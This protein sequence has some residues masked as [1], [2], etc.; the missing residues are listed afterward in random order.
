MALSGFVAIAVA[1]GLFILL[2]TWAADWFRSGRQAGAV[3]SNVIEA[4]V[5][6]AVIVGYIA[7]VGFL[8]DIRRVFQYHGAEHAVI[9]C[10]EAGDRVT[11]ENVLK[12]GV[13]HPRCGT[14]FLL[15][16]IVVKLVVNCF[17]G[18]PDLWV[19]MLLRVAVLPLVAALA[20]ELV[21]FAGRRRNS[22]FAH[23]LAVPG[24]TLEMLTTRAFDIKQAEVAIQALAAVAPGVS[25]PEGLEPPRP[26][27]PR[28]IAQQS[29]YGSEG[30]HVPVDKSSVTPSSL[31]HDQPTQP[32]HIVAAAPSAD[33]AEP[34]ET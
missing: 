19:R 7:G 16:V 28:N 32:P 26:W 34:E 31:F 20:Y 24:M 22:L 12:Y 8:P 1:V 27:E 2:P 10:F 23:A 33:R 13:L 14:S 6:L 30:S 15:T 17:L 9:N 21:L 11:P 4:A 25:L 3:T 5:R 29:G 18:W